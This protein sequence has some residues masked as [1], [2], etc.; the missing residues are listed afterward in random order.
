MDGGSESCIDGSD[1]LVGTEEGFVEVAVELLGTADG[2]NDCSCDKEGGSERIVDGPGEVV[3]VTEGA[4]EGVNGSTVTSEGTEDGTLDS[5]GASDAVDDGNT[6]AVGKAEGN[7]VVAL[8]P[9]GRKDGWGLGFVSDGDA[10]AVGPC[11]EGPIEA[12]GSWLK[13]GF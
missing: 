12:D 2:A 9:V 11:P 5:V 7:R 13:E 1:V 10:E 6:D 3:G 8:L 4:N